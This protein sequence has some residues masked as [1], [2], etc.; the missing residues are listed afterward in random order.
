VTLHLRGGDLSW[1]TSNGFWIEPKGKC[2]ENV[3]NGHSFRA[4]NDLFGEIRFDCVCFGMWGLE[5]KRLERGACFVSF[6][7]ARKSRDSKSMSR[8]SWRK[9]K[10]KF[11]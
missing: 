5:N 4:D 11:N 6:D 1:E 9:I 10:K 2:R 7:V 3:R 8:S